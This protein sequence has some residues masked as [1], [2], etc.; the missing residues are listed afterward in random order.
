MK[1][2]C[3]NILPLLTSLAGLA[4]AT[5]QGFDVSHYQSSVD[6]SAAYSG[7]LR[8]VMIKA[9]EGTTY[10]D[11][12]FS[13]HYEGATNAGF[14]RGGY[15]FA[16]PGETTGAAQAQYFFKNGGGWTADGITLPGMLD[17]EGDCAGLSASAMVSWIKDFVNE[18]H[19]LSGR[20][21]ILYFS[22]S[23]WKEC[24]GDSTAFSSTCPLDLASWNSAIGPIPGGW[25]FQTFWQYAD[26]N[27]YGGDSDSFN[28]AIANLQKLA[29]G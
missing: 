25:P 22:P 9:T 1:A 23:W 7:G 14:I 13:S 19:S 27:K 3:A 5:V 28:G 6:W 26:S 15:H 24:T 4:S 29:T 21:P 11:P 18:Y 8:F 20:Y 12:S 16:H 10:K 2:S 17:L